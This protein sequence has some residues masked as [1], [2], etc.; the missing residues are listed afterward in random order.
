M[1]VSRNQ[2]YEKAKETAQKAE[3]ENLAQSTGATQSKAEKKKKQEDDAS[4]RVSA[5]F[6]QMG[7]PC[8]SC[9]LKSFLAIFVIG[10][11]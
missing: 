10:A 7:Q 2:D 11:L 9:V 1:Y 8:E 5:V 3:S 4:H 6:L